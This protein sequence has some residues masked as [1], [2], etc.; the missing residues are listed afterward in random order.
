MNVYKFFK[1]FRALAESNTFV[2]VLTTSSEGIC[3]NVAIH[4]CNHQLDATDGVTK[5]AMNA[6]LAFGAQIFPKC[7]A[8]LFILL[9]TSQRL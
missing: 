2:I 7:I 1:V 4:K 3:N 9:K 8:N 6:G 5:S